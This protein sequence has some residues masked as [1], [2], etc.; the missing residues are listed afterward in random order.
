[1]MRSPRS[2]SIVVRRKS[3][4]LVVRERKM[5]DSRKGAWAWPFARGVATLVESLRLGTQALRF[6]ASHYEADLEA[7]DNA[8]EQ[9]KKAKNPGS[10]SIMT[11][12]LL[13]LLTSDLEPSRDPA[14]RA[15][16]QGGLLT[17]LP[18]LLA[19][20]VFVA[21]PQAFA[22]GATKIFKTNIDIRSPEFQAMT[23]L[24]KLAIVIG[25]MM[26]MRLMPEIRRVF[27]FHGA[28]H[29]AI[30]T[31]EADEALDVASARS[32]SRLHP[33]CGTAFLVMVVFVSILVFSSIGPFLPKIALGG[34]GENLLFFLM[35]LPFLPV[36]A[37]IT[38]EIQ[39]LTA[40][41]CLTGPLRALLYPGFAVQ[42]ITTIEPDDK[43]LEVALASLRATLWREQ[44]GDS[45][46]T[47]E[48]RTFGSFDELMADSGY[49]PP[50][51]SQ[52][53]HA[54]S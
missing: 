2:F 36:I 47:L 16:T 24:F 54:A 13:G 1:M 48:D 42:L 8:K 45:T 12:G 26:I 17:K 28:E 39:R 49:C 3:G 4:S 27:M 29:K 38:Y 35:K 53:S 31:Y 51:S 40:R 10:L 22:F 50:A 30:A 32:K 46:N 5:S 15:E 41:F 25:Y 21:L 6:S 34:I 9:A 14:P 11:A 19:L 37:A 18:I 20:L 43:Q 23:G 52:E 7:E 33:R 44:A